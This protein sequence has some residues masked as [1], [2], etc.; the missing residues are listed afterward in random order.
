[1]RFIFCCSLLFVAAMA[2]AED[3]TLQAEATLSGGT[4]VDIIISPTPEVAHFLTLVPAD[5]AEGKY[6]DYQ[7]VLNKSS[8]T[9][10][11]PVQPGE[12]ELRLLE[13][14]SGYATLS[15]RAL[16]ITPAE[17]SLTAP[18]QAQAG[19]PVSIAWEGPAGQGDYITVVAV[20]TPGEEDG[21]Y[22]YT[23]R[24]PVSLIMPD[25]PGEYELRY[26]TR[27]KEKLAS[28]PIVVEGYDVQM[29]APRQ[30][31]AGAS[32]AIE[33]SGVQNSGDFITIVAPGTA[34]RKYDEYVYAKSSPATMAAPETPGEYEIRY[35]SANEYRT[36]ASAPLTVGGVDASV[37]APVSAVAGARIEIAW[38]GPDNRGDYLT[39]V[40]AGTPD[41]QYDRYVYTSKGTPV[42][43]DTPAAPGEYEIRY[44][45]ARND[46]V[47]ARQPVTLTDPSASLS[48]PE[49]VET[50][51]VFPVLWEGDGNPLDY[52]AITE[53]GNPRRYFH[54]AYVQ[55][56]NPVSLQAP[57]DEGEYE[58]HYLTEADQ[59]LAVQP[60]TVVASKAPG[61]LRVVS[62]DPA[63]ASV[64]SD[65]AVEVILDASGSMLQRLDGN[66]RIDIARRAVTDLI[67]DA[68]AQVPNDLAGIEGEAVVVLVTDGEETCEGDP[69][70]VIE[71][72]RSSGYDIRVNIVG[73]AIDEAALKQEFAAWANAGGG[74]YYDAADAGQLGNGIR[75]ALRLPYTVLDVEGGQIAT[76][77]VGGEP[78]LLGSGRYSVVVNGA[79]FDVAVEA[80]SESVLELP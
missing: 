47:L 62:T 37:S 42:R 57:T 11:T 1:M 7:Y 77:V 53:A 6:G 27:R 35:L 45:T 30:V 21:R 60:I 69:R 12:Y 15:R 61:S 44:Q 68:L 78:I 5:T 20:G 52:I 49:T 18:G 70:K 40:P 34:E 66:R 2:A 32:V 55:R 23:S 76:G 72:L 19:T 36:L 26:L 64:G 73:F 48:G 3:F 39:L 17:V 65:V 58:L 79:A 67:S 29:S 74:S 59:S 63:R 56:G 50:R 22:A 4:P 51:E 33:W 9:L 43:F 80:D 14:V 46:I 54:Y 75:N 10:Q 13:N 8:V 31:A 41:G 16:T 25:T 28:R 71:T 38:S 24:N